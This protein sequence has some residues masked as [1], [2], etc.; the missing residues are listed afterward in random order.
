M[1]KGGPTAENLDATAGKD[2]KESP[3]APRIETPEKV[4][5]PVK[6]HDAEPAKNDSDSTR[7]SQTAEH[8]TKGPNKVPRPGIPVLKVGSDDNDVHQ[9]PAFEKKKKAREN[10][11]LA[12]RHLELDLDELSYLLPQMLNLHKLL[13]R[14]QRRRSGR[15]RRRSSAVKDLRSPVRSV[16]DPENADLADTLQP[17]DSMVDTEEEKRNQRG[18][19]FDPKIY[20]RRNQDVRSHNSC[21][22]LRQIFRILTTSNGYPILWRICALR[23]LKFRLRFFCFPG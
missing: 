15:R 1:P 18:K 2:P 22:S 19:S 6:S 8:Q 23:M 10:R 3:A 17:R 7:T 11:A 16:T 13:R 4:P 5:D 20:R 21:Y 12:N 9:E 14:K